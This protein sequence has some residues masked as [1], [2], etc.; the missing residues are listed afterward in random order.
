MEYTVRIERIFDHADDVRSIFLRAVGQPIP[1]FLPGMFVSIKMPLVDGERVR[2][3]TLASLPDDGEPHEIV[4]NLVPNGPGAAWLFARRVADELRLTG[5]YGAFTFTGTP[6]ANL[7][8][9]AEDTAIA[10]IRPMI[11]RAL[12][13][14]SDNHVELLYGADRRD[15]LLYLSE[16]EALSA[17]HSRFQVTTLVIERGREA[18]Y[19]RLAEEARQRW[20]ESDAERSRHFYICGVGAG[21]FGLR[22]LLR[23]AGYERRAVHYEKW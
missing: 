4:F 19:A 13:A 23:R 1:Q 9:I 8:F 15:H 21:V 22:D 12:T 3:Y 7:V 2:P 17:R 18:L 11:R 5:P 10:P 14:S 20:I 6:A 16:F